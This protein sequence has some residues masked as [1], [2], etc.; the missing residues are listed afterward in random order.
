MFSDDIEIRNGDSH[1]MID[2]IS[3][4]RINQA[5]YVIIGDHVWLPTHVRVLKGSSIPSMSVVGN[6]AIVTSELSC[7]NGL[8]AGVPCRLIKEN[9]DWDRYKL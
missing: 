7:K 1:S 2:T 9:I 3:N 5:E 6:S 4:Q 8:Y